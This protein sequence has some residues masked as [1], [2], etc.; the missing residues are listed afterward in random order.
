MAKE[1]CKKCKDLYYE[2][3]RNPYNLIKILECGCVDKPTHLIATPEQ[4]EVF[5]LS[6]KGLT[7]IQIAEELGT[8]Q[9]HIS[10]VLKSLERQNPLLADRIRIMK[11]KRLPLRRYKW[12]DSKAH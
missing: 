12:T 10:R 5:K 4:L 1:P 8:K 2:D 6:R 3:P 9:N 7:Q 11:D